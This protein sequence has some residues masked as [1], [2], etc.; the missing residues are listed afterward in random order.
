MNVLFDELS[1]SFQGISGY[2]LEPSNIEASVEF[3][4]P[5][6]R[7]FIGQHIHI[8]IMIQYLGW[9]H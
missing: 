7:N 5:F 8:H 9:R 3:D 2:Y 6:L 4:N 1:N